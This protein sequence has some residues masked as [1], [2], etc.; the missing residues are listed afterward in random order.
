L[1]MPS[2]KSVRT[3][4]FSPPSSSNPQASALMSS[5]SYRPFPC[6]PSLTQLDLRSNRLRYIPRHVC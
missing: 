2:L 4:S 6:F 1:L 3:V 5:T